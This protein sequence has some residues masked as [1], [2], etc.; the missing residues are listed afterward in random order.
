LGARALERGVIV[1]TAGHI[2][3]GKTAL[4]KA[5]TGVDTDRLPEEKRRGITIDLGFAPL[6]LEG[7]GTVGLID[8]PGHEDFVRSMLVGASGIDVGLLVI[9]ADEGV[10]PQTREHLLILSLLE[11]PGLVVALTKSDA[12]EEDWLA[13]V[14]SD[15]EA[16]IAESRWQK[17]AIVSCSAVTNSGI[18][19][20]RAALIQAL[21]AAA[22]KPPDDLFRLPVDRVFSVRGTGTVV[23]GTVW[24]G[25]V[26]READV[27]LLPSGRHARLKKIEQ[28]GAA[29]PVAR[30]GVRAALALAGVDVSEVSRGSVV[31]AD[32][33]WRATSLF[34]A[35]VTMDSPAAGPLKPRTRVRL[36]SAAM[37]VGA[38]VTFLEAAA[39]GH[40]RLRLARITTD[41]PIPVRGGDRFVLRLP[42]PVGT[43]GGGIVLDPY[44]RRRS[45][46]PLN[47]ERSQLTVD[48]SKRLEWML[49]TEG[50]RGIAIA[51]IVVRSGMTPHD[52]NAT[53]AGA[54]G[55]VGSNNLFSSAAVESTMAQIRMIIAEYEIRS[56]LSR[57]VPAQTLRGGLRVNEELADISIREMEAD[58][59]IETDGPLIRRKGW[60]PNPS[61]SDVKLG[62]AVVHDICASGRE[63]PSVAELMAR[64]GK[65]VPSVLGF[66]ERDGRIVKVQADRFYETHV[67]ADMVGRLRE[68]LVPG[69]VYVPAQL[70]DVLGLSRKYLIPFLEFCDRKGIT[71]RRG[72]GRVLRASSSVVLD[73]PQ[74]QS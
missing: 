38:R 2:D 47:G 14:R 51:E 50:V 46:T 49:E 70:R 48:A 4:V 33:G 27:R 58:G 71:E 13:L 34:E 54:R 73:T 6:A 61:E 26:A 37:E 45:M 9:A 8:V 44:A 72:E 57:G 10:M 29:V 32:H 66:L 62:D 18:D 53:I 22:A 64:H 74:P 12:V 17:A 60:V 21:S 3:H 63:P 5:L 7:L 41:D 55:R 23:T 68:R 39:I 19:D 56:P 40:N 59:E 16:F 11:I 69:T 24:S 52:V 1:G 67:L 43:I 25:A 20:L 15:V 42:A 30:T 36:H 65:E 28:H 31:V 35:F